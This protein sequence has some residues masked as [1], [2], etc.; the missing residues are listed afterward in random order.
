[1]SNNPTD[2]DLDDRVKMSWRDFIEFLEAAGAALTLPSL[3]P[4]G[5]AFGVNG[6]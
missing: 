4:L 2:S 5:K 1:M 6:R 3:V